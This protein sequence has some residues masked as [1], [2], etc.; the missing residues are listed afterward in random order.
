MP[1]THYHIKQRNGIS[2]RGPIHGSGG[3]VGGGPHNRRR[4]Q[5]EIDHATQ[6]EPLGIF[7]PKPGHARMYTDYGPDG[8]TPIDVDLRGAVLLDE[9]DR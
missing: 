2:V 6:G 5:L 9:G 8:G 3:I 1:A 7:E 4:L